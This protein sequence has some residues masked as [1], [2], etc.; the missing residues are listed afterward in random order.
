[1]L[2]EKT[3]GADAAKALLPLIEQL[4]EI[5]D[6]EIT[7]STL[8]GMRDV[9]NAAIQSG[10]DDT[11]K[12]ARDQFR[13]QGLG[14]EE[15]I[16]FTNNLVA[17]LKAEVDENEYSS[18]RT[19]MYYALANAVGLSFY[20]A[21]DIL[22]NADATVGWELLTDMAKVP[23]YA[24]DDD[25]CADIYAIEDTIIPKHAC[26]VQVRTGLKA[27]IPRGWFLELRAR[28]GMSMRTPL[29]LSNCIGTIDTSYKGEIMVLFD[30]ISGKDYTIQAGDRIA[31]IR[32]EPA[33]K[34]RSEVVDNVGES[35]RGE[36]GFGSSGK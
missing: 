14:R 25:A 16:E 35:E 8:E 23:T 26:G 27:R 3:L 9:F 2:F 24:H 15:A 32:L 22:D 13:A 1:M 18:V 6:E 4:E 12:A 28:S 10:A 17:A 30:N 5:K 11:I 7:P 31:Q 36:G 20:A 34:F 21:A 29:R 19:E 33:Y